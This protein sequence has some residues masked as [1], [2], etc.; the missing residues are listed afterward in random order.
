MNLL[1]LGLG[2]FFGALSRFALSQWT[3]TFWT[4]DFPLAT[5]A[6]NV[7]GSFLLGLVVGLHL[8]SPWMLFLGTGFLGS[9]T[10]FSTFK[11]ETLQLVQHENRRTL[12]LYLGMSY[13]LGIGAAFLGLVCALAMH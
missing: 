6:G 7:S 3:K 11:L 10:T 12:I 2:A 4:R 9:F 1:A 5:F 13:V 8:D